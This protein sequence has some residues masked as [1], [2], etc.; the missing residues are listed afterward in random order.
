MTS[1]AR[2]NRTDAPLV[3][4]D[5]EILCLECARMLGKLPPADPQKE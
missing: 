3:R 2:C 5:D 4:A 1:C